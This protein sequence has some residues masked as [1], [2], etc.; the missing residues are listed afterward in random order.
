MPVTV[1]NT[2][3]AARVAGAKRPGWG[4]SS[5]PNQIQNSTW[6]TLMGYGPAQRPMNAFFYKRKF[7]DHRDVQFGGTGS[8]QGQIDDAN[9]A[10]NVYRCPVDTGYGGFHFT[11]WA[12]SGYSSFDHYGNSYACNTMWIASAAVC[13]RS[14]NSPFMRPASRIPDPANTVMYLENVGRFA[15]RINLGQPCIPEI[16]ETPPCDTCSGCG[17]GSMNWVAAGMPPIHGWHGED[18]TFNVAFCDGAAAPRFIRGHTR[19]QPMLGSYPSISEGPVIIPPNYCD[20]HCVIIRRPDWQYDCL[21][22]API[23]TTFPI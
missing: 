17:I 13:A 7:I 1:E 15:W 22:D 21:P 6:G 20:W 10:L 19:P 2:N 23:P 14:S 11:S 12:D 18:W 16:G 8:L 3:G 4:S 9:L 5:D